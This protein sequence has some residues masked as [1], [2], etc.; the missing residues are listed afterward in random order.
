M[1]TR[2][3]RSCGLSRAETLK[4][5][6]SFLVPLVIGIFTIVTTIQQYQ[7]NYQN[8]LKDL[9]IA[10]R[11]RDQEQKQAD[12]LQQ[13][14]VFDVY[15]KEMGEL[16]LK[17]KVHNVNNTELDQQWK[18]ARVETLSVLRQ[19]DAKRKSYLIQFL[20]EA[21]LLFA[22]RSA[23]DLGGADLSEI[24]LTGHVGLEINYDYIALTHVVLTNTS[25]V[26]LHLL[27][28]IPQEI[29]NSILPNG[30]YVFYS[31]D[32]L[33]SDLFNESVNLIINGDM[34]CQ[35]NINSTEIFGWENHSKLIAIIT[36]Y[37]ESPSFIG[38]VSENDCLLWGE[39]RNSS[40]DFLS[41]ILLV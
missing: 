23:I 41:V 4:V 16:L 8:R 25:F 5:F 39:I 10:T 26:N 18:L 2:R 24:I 35:T 34:N 36:K 6:G 31:N 37:S 21:E 12:L 33:Q 38:N 22:N 11:L 40:K 20:Y 13:E 3:N 27:K 15:M 19:L 17:L 30:S 7:I 14:T 9:E 28:A 29:M 32:S 1:L